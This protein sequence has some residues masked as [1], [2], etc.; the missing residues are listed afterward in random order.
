MKIKN[1]ISSS[2]L[3]ATLLTSVSPIAH[4]GWVSAMDGNIP[5]GTVISGHEANGTKLYACR[6]TVNGGIHPGKIRRGFKACNIP[7]GGKVI[8]I[9]QYQTYVIWQRASNGQVPSNAVVTGHES[10]AEQLFSCKA[11][12]NGGVHSGKIR[13]GFNGCHIGWGGEEISINH[14]QVLI[15]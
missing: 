9:K 13:I 2:I 5:N 8:S 3:A 4:A 10:N 12:Y 1:N 6:A 15:H 14:Y 7:W 11:N